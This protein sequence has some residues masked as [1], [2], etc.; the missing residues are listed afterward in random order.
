VQCLLP[1]SSGFNCNSGGNVCISCKKIEGV[2]LTWDFM[3]LLSKTVQSKIQAE[4]KEKK[5]RKGTHR[6][7]IKSM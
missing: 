7:P 2:H 1:C 5:K 6:K 3:T 4:N